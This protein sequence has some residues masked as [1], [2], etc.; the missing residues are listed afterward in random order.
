MADNPPPNFG[1]QP[2]VGSPYG[3][4]TPTEPK[5]RSGSWLAI[6]LAAIATAVAVAALIVALMRPSA[7]IALP[8]EKT[9]ATYTSAET[10]AA[11]QQLCDQYKMAARA[12]QVDTNGDDKALGRIAL[13]NAAVILDRAAADPALDAQHRDAARAL[14]MAYL[15]DTAKSSNGAATESE[16]R[17]AL[18]DVNAK[19]AAMKKVCGGG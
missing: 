16:F 14:A 13:T 3:Q 1:G 12:V 19:D 15:T 8:T 2:P 5:K 9:Q 17:A 18:D 6:A 11:Q 10:A 7:P 4:W